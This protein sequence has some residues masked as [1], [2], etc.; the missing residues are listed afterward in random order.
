M[1]WNSLREH[2]IKLYNERNLKINCVCAAVLPQHLTCNN[3]VVVRIKVAIKWGL[4][5]RSVF[6]DG[7]N[8]LNG[9]WYGNRDI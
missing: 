4:E 7:G 2:L 1:S 3:L 9:F 6:R 8:L 5:L